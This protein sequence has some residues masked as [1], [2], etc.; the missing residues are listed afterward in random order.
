M[1]PENKTRWHIETKHTK[2]WNKEVRQISQDASERF[3]RN[4][5]GKSDSG[6][7]PSN[8]RFRPEKVIGVRE[9]LTGEHRTNSDLPS[10]LKLVDSVN[11]KEKS[12]SSIKDSKTKRYLGSGKRPKWFDDSPKGR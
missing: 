6:Y 3:W 8:H 2:I 10:S 7:K 12:K 5:L 11:K 4:I 9:F 1:V